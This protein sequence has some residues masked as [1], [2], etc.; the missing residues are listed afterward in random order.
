MNAFA[1]ATRQAEISKG[2]LAW[3]GRARVL[4]GCWCGEARGSGGVIS[5][6]GRPKEVPAARGWRCGHP[7]CGGGVVVAGLAGSA[8]TSGSAV[9]DAASAAGDKARTPFFL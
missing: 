8:V 9:D 5:A 6:I 4:A 7:G 1:P 3:H 2:V